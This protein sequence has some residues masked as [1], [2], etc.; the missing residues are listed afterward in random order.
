ML[1]AREELL[2]SAGS[3][4]KVGWQ[5]LLSAGDGSMNLEVKAG[6]SLGDVWVLFILEN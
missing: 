6:G 3:S 2:L 4:N 5:K 1:I